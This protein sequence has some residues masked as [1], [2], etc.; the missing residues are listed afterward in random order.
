[1]AALRRVAVVP[2]LPKT[3]SGKILGAMRAMAEG[4]QVEVP[5]TIED[6]DALTEVGLTLRAP[7]A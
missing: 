6:P 4:S 1:M 3:R 5:S 7:P 2:R